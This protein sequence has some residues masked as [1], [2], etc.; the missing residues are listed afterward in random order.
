MF[1]PRVD[2][3]RGLQNLSSLLCRPGQLL[4]AEEVT[5]CTHLQH[6]DHSWVGVQ[7]WSQ[8]EEKSHS[9][10]S[11]PHKNP[12][13]QPHLYLYVCNSGAQSVLH[14]GNEVIGLLLCQTL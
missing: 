6:C 7:A 10:T 3:Q 13:S 1:L 9:Q 5:C 2:L 4:G 14:P 12:T 8:L 11:K